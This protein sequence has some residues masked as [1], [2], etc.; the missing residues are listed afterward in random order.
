MK[1]SQAVERLT[2]ITILLAKVTTW[3]L[4]ISL[5]TAYFSTQLKGLPDRYSQETYWVIFGVMSAVTIIFLSSF[6]Y[7]SGTMEGPV[8]Y[9]SLTEKLVAKI[10]RRDV[11]SGKKIQSEKKI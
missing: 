5:M 3:F 8:I 6:G 2:R 1:E 7:L 9:R 11:L 4:P 10:L